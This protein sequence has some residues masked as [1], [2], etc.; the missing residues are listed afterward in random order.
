MYQADAGG[1]QSYTGA[2]PRSAA[3]TG[4][5]PLAS[6]PGLIA[7][8]QIWASGSLVGVLHFGSATSPPGTA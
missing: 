2:R 1:C 8:G 6:V 7:A 5:L 4:S 3:L